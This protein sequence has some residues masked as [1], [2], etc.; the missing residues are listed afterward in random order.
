MNLFYFYQKRLNKLNETK[1][2]IKWENFVQYSMR[3]FIVWLLIIWV[4]SSIVFGYFIFD[5]AGIFLGVI[6]TIIFALYLGY[7]LIIQSIKFLALNSDRFIKA[8]M[9][10]ESS[11]IN[12]TKKED[13]VED[14]IYEDE[15]LFED[16]FEY[17]DD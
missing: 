6:L 2:I 10:Q 15:I 13:V 14:F 17:E 1:F 12:S 9:N 3:K 11:V 4:V 16:E 7:I 8:K 5:L